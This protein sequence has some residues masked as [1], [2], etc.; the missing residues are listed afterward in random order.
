MP[1]KP[2]TSL[3]VRQIS[4]VMMFV[5]KLNN[6]ARVRSAITV[7]AMHALP[8]RSPMPLTVASIWRAPFASPASVFAVAKPR[9]SWQCTL[10][11]TP[12]EAKW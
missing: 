4:F 7:S 11:V 9:S 5:S 12:A 6:G 2:L 3:L 8:A 10:T 1:V